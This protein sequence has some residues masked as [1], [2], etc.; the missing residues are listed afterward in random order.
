MCKVFMMDK[1]KNNK[2]SYILKS[3][4]NTSGYSIEFGDASYENTLEERIQAAR[5]ASLTVKQEK[6]QNSKEKILTNSRNAI[7]KNDTDFNNKTVKKTTNIVNEFKIKNEHFK[8]TINDYSPNSIL[9]RDRNSNL[10]DINNTSDFLKPVFKGGSS[11]QQRLESIK[12][13]KKL[14]NNSSCE[15]D[16]T[17][18]AI[19]LTKNVNFQHSLSKNNNSKHTSTNFTQHYEYK[20]KSTI[21]NKCNESS[22]LCGHCNRTKN[23]TTSSSKF[24]Y[25]IFLNL[26]K[27]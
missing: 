12:C 14:F 15:F 1:N 5:L 20:T 16:K 21:Q 8:Q 24:R 2:K 13:N 7:L 3:L 4:N 10:Q 25:Y 27:C 17:K 9:T 6:Q 22:T 26:C 19:K 18:D 11:M 23:S